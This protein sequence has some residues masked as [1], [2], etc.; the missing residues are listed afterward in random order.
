M[1]FLDKLLGRSK[2]TAGDVAD[3]SKEPSGAVKDET[4]TMIGPKQ[5]GHEQDEEG[6]HDDNTDE[7]SSGSAT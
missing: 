3:M 1:G 2:G 7:Q 6:S 5:G 4:D